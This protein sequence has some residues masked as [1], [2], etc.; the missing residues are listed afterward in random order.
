[1]EQCLQEISKLNQETLK[2][3]LDVDFTDRARKQDAIGPDECRYYVDDEREALTKQQDNMLRQQALKDLD[4]KLYVS[5]R[6]N[7]INANCKKSVKFSDEN[8]KKCQHYKPT[9]HCLTCC[10]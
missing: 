3:V 8:D 7:D 5:T 10:P 1:M 6:C 2:P 9:G 4:P